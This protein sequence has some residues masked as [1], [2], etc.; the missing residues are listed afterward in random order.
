MNDKT[1]FISRCSAG[2]RK[3][4][5]V[6]YLGEEIH[7][8]NEPFASGY[9]ETARKADNQAT[10]TSRKMYPERHSHRWLL[11]ENAKQVRR[12]VLAREK[13]KKQADASPFAD[14]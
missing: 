1:I 10:T 3:W 6:A 14:V 13:A 8:G 2:K 9:A 7:S 5:W 4:F 12:S 11:A